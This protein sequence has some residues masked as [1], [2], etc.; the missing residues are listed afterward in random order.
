MG[1]A[2][3]VTATYWN[4]AGVAA[5]TDEVQISLMHAV[6]R[7]AGL[8]SFNYI[9]AINQMSPWLALGASWIHA[10][11][12]DIPIYPAFDPNIGPGERRDIAKY[13]PNFEPTSFLS[14]SENAYVLTMAA[15]FAISQEWWDNFGRNSQPPEFLFGVNVKRISQ[16]L[17]GASADGVSFD[18]G[19]LIRVLDTNATVGAEG[20]GGFSVRLN[21]QDISKTT[22]TWNTE[23]QRKSIPTN[24]KLG[25]SYHN[26]LLFSHQLVLA[27]EHETRYGGQNH[28]GLE[29]QFS[30]PLTL[31]VGLRDGDFTG[32]VGMHIDRFRLDYALLTNDLISTHF[33]SLL[34]SF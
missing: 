26:D 15:R 34:A 16:S 29:Y 22:L 4:P 23:S 2:N 8:G 21:V 11:V 20:F 24:V 27:Y 10:G 9:V 32:G 12:D 18:A 19:V 7:S 6:R 1:V 13:R 28:F 31:R 5:L 30:N 33:L 25:F 3:D 17:I 14:D